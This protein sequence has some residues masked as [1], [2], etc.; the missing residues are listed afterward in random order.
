MLASRAAT[1]IFDVFAIRHVRFM[2]A[3]LRPSTSIVSCVN[4]SHT[5]VEV[6]AVADIAYFGEVHQHFG[7]LIASFTAPLFVSV[8]TSTVQI[9]GILTHPT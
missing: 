6:D 7:H 5:A 2:M 4:V 9:S 3:S 8:S 1:G